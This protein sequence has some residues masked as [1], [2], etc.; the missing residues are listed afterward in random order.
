M[1]KFSNEIK[2]YALKNALEFEKADVSKILPKLFQHGMQ[3]DEIKEIMPEIQK[4]AKEVNHI[5]KEQREKLFLEYKQFMKEHEEKEK[6]LP[7]L[8]NAK[9]KKVVL[10]IAPFPSGALHLGNAKTF[11]I[12]ALYAEKY[13][14]ELILVMDDTIGSA[15]KT[16]QE[17]SYKLIKDALD[18]LKINYSKMLSLKEIFLMNIPLKKL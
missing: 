3:K 15:E 17:E 4:I 6:G 16:V 2:A 5:S 11:I 12:N 7:E 18:W 10:R 8:P 13:K 9:S 1:A 14:G